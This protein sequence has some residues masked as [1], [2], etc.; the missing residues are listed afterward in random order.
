MYIYKIKKKISLSVLSLSVLSLSLSC[1][2]SV[3]F[4][5]LFVLLF[6]LR[7]RESPPEKKNWCHFPRSAELIEVRIKCDGK[8]SL[9]P[10]LVPQA[11]DSPRRSSR[12]QFRHP[13]LRFRATWRN[14]RPF[15]LLRPLFQPFPLSFSF[16]SLSFPF[17]VSSFFPSPR[18]TT[19]F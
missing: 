11:G 6:L 10:L 5:C 12:R 14:P 19:R 2:V 13:L 9:Q 16:R 1:C 8:R 15:L 18:T 17:S 7:E 4:I 3:H